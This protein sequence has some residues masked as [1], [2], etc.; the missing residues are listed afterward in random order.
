MD[1]YSPINASSTSLSC[2]N[3]LISQLTGY[4]ATYAHLYYCIVKVPDQLFQKLAVFARGGQVR[5]N[6]GIV[7]SSVGRVLEDMM[8]LYC[9]HK[10]ADHRLRRHRRY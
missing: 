7:G 3:Y 9:S 8:V 4:V 2:R 6:N 5:G 10:G 1:S